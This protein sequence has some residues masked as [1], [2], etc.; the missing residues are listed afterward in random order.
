MVTRRECASRG[1]RRDNVCDVMIP[2]TRSRW[3]YNAGAISGAVSVRAAERRLVRRAAFAQCA[4]VTESDLMHPH[5]NRFTQ[6]PRSVRKP[7]LN[8]NIGTV[9]VTRNSRAS[10]RN[11][12]YDEHRS[13]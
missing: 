7:T 1:E 8:A 10:E 13:K 6:Y 12:T 11:A 5:R 4:A 3:A 2:E 9:Q